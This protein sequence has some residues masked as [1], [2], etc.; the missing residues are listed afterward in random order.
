MMIMIKIFTKKDCNQCA[1]VKEFL[2]LKGL[3][4]EEINLSEK[5]NREARAYY[6][7]KGYETLPIIEG[8]GWTI[9][10]YNEILLEEFTSD[11]Y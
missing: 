1:N 7:S 9:Q 2:N 8:D 6:R 5:D 3:E 11:W 10:G 4:W